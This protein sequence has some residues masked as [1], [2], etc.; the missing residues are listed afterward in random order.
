MVLFICFAMFN[1]V[2][3]NIDTFFL[4]LALLLAYKHVYIQMYNVK[5]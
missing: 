2:H 4:A 3:F 5:I 1:Y